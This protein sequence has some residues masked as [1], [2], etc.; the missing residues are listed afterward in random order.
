MEGAG[1]V[2]F[3]VVIGILGLALVGFVRV[4]KLLFFGGRDEPRVIVER[5]QEPL[6]RTEKLGVV[7]EVMGMRMPDDLREEYQRLRGW[8]VAPAPAASP[9]PAAAPAPAPHPTAAPDP[10][11]A[12]VTPP[13]RAAEAP[14][15]ERPVARPVAADAR[16]ELAVPP[17]VAAAAPHAPHWLRS[18]LSFEN[19]IFLLAAC[20]VLGGTLYVVATTWGRVPGHWRHLF[21]EGVIL[22]YGTALLG[23]A[24]LLDR[25]LHL[26]AAARFLG[27]TA[28]ITS[29][30]AAVIACAAFAQSTVAGVL[31][32]ALVAAVGALDARAV[33]RLEGQRGSAPAAFGG[34]LALLAAVGAVAGAHPSGAAALLVAAVVAGGPIWLSR[35][36]TPTIA[37]RALAVALPVAAILLAVGGWM[38]AA[39][40]GPALVAAGGT[41][42]AVGVATMGPPAA[43]VLVGLQAAALVLARGDATLSVASLAVGLVVALGRLASLGEA[44]RAALERRLVGAI[45]AAEWCGLAFLWAPAARLVSGGLL[46]AWNGPAAL[47]FALAPLA[48]LTRSPADSSSRAAA[49]AA[50]AAIVAGALVTALGAFPSLGLP[51]ISTGAG[52]AALLYFWAWRAEPADAGWPWVCAHAAGLLAVWIAARVLAPHLAAAALASAALPLLLPRGRA[53]RLV[54]AVVV[55]CAVGVAV[56]D[57]APGAWLAALAAAYGLAHLLRPIRL[58]DHDRGEDDGWTTRAVAPLALVGVLALAL[59]VASGPGAPLVPLARWPLVLALGVAPL[60]AWVVARGGPAFLAVEVVLGV[61]AIALGGEGL[62]A[63]A[64]ATALVVGRRPGAISAASSSLLPLAALALAQAARPELVAGAL[65]VAGAALLARPA[66]GAPWWRWLGLPALVSAVL[67]AAFAH[68]AGHA[69]R[70]EPDLWPLVAAAALAPFAL[71]TWRG[72]PAHI[73]DEV[74]VGAGLLAAAA[75]ADAFAGEAASRAAVRAAAGA[76]A[77]LAAGLLAANRAGGRTQRA[78]WVGALLLAP[79]AVVPLF[80]SPLFFGPALAAVASV[81]ALGAASKR[82]GA[83]DVGAWALAAALP[84]G[85]W[86]LA[87]VAKR[88]STGAPPEHLLPALGG[89]TALLGVAIALDGPRFA[90]SPPAF[91]RGL[92]LVALALAAAFTAAGAALVEAPEPRDAALTL[93][94]LVFIATLALVIAFRERRGWPFYVAEGTLGAAYAYLRLRT[95]WLSG[96]GD[97]DGVVACAGGF[98]CLGAEH[99]LRRLR[100]GLG[101]D[102]SRLLATLSPVLSVLFLRPSAPLTGLGTALAAA[103]LAG[104]ARDRSRPLYGWLAAILANLSLVALWARLDV[105]SPVAY[106]LP[107]GLTLALLCDLYAAELGERAGLL[108]TTAALL[109]FAATS[110]E[111]FQFQSVWPAVALG[112]TAVAAVLGGIHVRARAYLT[113]GFAALLLDIVANLT[114][115]GIHDRLVGGAIGMTSGV[116]LFA[117][118]VT[119]SRHKE[120]ALERYRQIMAWPW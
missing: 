78:W 115:W 60:A 52:A 54:G 79:A 67:V 16:E 3:I 41:I 49:R 30:G 47:P 71:G 104:R 93:A 83:R 80:A 113:M 66:P 53:H 98:V 11:A 99:G 42:A 114:R 17:E 22:F 50:V 69:P 10:A 108:R 51:S 39:Y 13:A 86:A 20:L 117:L 87:A 97:W 9:G 100:D 26:P 57:G 102:E 85:W 55:P 63:L 111:M 103:F 5:V 119:V 75:L 89:V 24:A 62:V 18:F 33:L 31:G 109:S 29:V 15:A 23:A 116:A 12:R 65:L 96:F 19:T 88:F 27:A 59:L 7:W 72:A 74:L 32:A 94:A 107:A 84:A 77:A 45:V 46:A 120:R 112:G 2:I 118:G 56:A 106:A 91:R 68:A 82:L 61:G 36:A 105:H 38:P 73:R 1:I 40:I 43:L 8:R 28:G 95:P 101:A 37:L 64:L 92:V 44:P 25:R 35:V 58:A 110:W 90:L 81:T 76:L 48:L 21:L 6:T 14:A 34:G 4:V 70:L